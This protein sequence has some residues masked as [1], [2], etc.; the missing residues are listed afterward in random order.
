MS[1]KGLLFGL[2]TA[3]LGISCLFLSLNKLLLLTILLPPS[4]IFLKPD[5]FYDLYFFSILILGYAWILNG[6]KTIFKIIIRSA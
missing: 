6:L 3:V 5:L 2:L 1:Y 4:F